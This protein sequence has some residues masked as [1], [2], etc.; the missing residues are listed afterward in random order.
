M[1]LLSY[2]N[3]SQKFVFGQPVRYISNEQLLLSKLSGGFNL[4]VYV[5]GSFHRSSYI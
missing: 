4:A 5:K 3:G 2:P 1:S